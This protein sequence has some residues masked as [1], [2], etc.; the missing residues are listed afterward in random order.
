ML[1]LPMPEAKTYLKL[2]NIFGIIQIFLTIYYIK[3]TKSHL[4]S[5]L[6]GNI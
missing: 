1:S 5:I 3:K 6:G 4:Y 2:R